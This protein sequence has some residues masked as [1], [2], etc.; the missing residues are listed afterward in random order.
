MLLEVSTDLLRQLAALLLAIALLPAAPDRSVPSV[1]IVT[2][3][4]GAQVGAA[5]ASAGTTLYAGDTLSTDAQG[6]LGVRNA[7]FQLQLKSQSAVVLRPLSAPEKGT[8]I[9]LASGGIELSTAARAFLVVLAAG[10]TLRPLPDNAVL[11]SIELHGPREVHIYL[12][13]GSM[14]LDYRSETAVLEESNSYGVLLD[15]TDKEIAVAANLDP[16]AND[17]KP[18]GKRPLFLLILI[19]VAVGVAVPVILHEL[20]SPHVP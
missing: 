10:A 13:R 19:A 15:P 2:F 20:E 12:R 1:G 17:R 5:A 3:S 7:D 9:G 18:P 4:R 8:E 14:K 16:R 11:A 6:V